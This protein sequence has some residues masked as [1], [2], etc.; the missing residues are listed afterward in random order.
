MADPRVVEDPKKISVVTYRELRELAYMGA[1]VFHEEAMFPVQEAGIPTHILN[2]NEPKDSGTVI[3]AERKSDKDIR[4]I[5]GIA[6]RKGFSVLTI[7]KALMN[8]EIGFVRKSS[9]FLNKTASAWSIC[10]AE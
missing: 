1:N 9:P 6:G 8:Q 3:V 2:T 5:T 10:Q 4:A 7:E